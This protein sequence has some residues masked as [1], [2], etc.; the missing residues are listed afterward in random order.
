MSNATDQITI[1][2]A[3]NPKH[4]KKGR[5]CQTGRCTPFDCIRQIEDLIDNPAIC[6]EK[7]NFKLCRFEKMH[8]YQCPPG[9]KV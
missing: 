8:E 6:I 7:V 3:F 2:R 5:P 4:L 9:R 1:L